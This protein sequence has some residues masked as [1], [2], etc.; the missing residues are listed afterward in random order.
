MA[1]AGWWLGVGWLT[2][3]WPGWLPIKPNAALALVLGGIALW[4]LAVE[5]VPGG[6]RAGPFDLTLSAL[7]AAI[8]LLTLVEHLSGIDLRIDELLIQGAPLAGGAATSA[9]MPPITAVGA[10]LIGSAFLLLQLRRFTWGQAV[11]VGALTL[12][13][14]PLL[15]DLYA[16]T[17]FRRRAFFGFIAPHAELGFLLLAVGGLCARV[18]YGLMAYGSGAGLGARNLR[19]VLP[20]TVVVLVTVGGLQLWGEGLGLF[21]SPTGTALMVLASLVLVGIGLW[22]ENRQTQRMERERDTFFS[23]GADL[24]CIADFEGHFL[25]VNPAFAQVLGWSDSDL[26]SRPFLEFVHPD[27]REATVA[28]MGELVTGKTTLRFLNRYGCPDG[29]WKW[30]SWTAVPRVEDGL[31]FASARDVTGLRAAQDSLQESE[32]NLAITLQSIGDGV[33]AT[34]ARGI[35]TRLNSVAETLTGWKEADALGRP[36]GEVFRVVNE[37][38]RLPAE[39]PAEAVL[40]TGS[41]QG[42]TNHTLLLARDGSERPI[43]DSAAPILD[44][45]GLL[46]GVV[47]VFRDVTAEREADRALERL[48]AELEVRVRERTAQLARSEKRLSDFFENAPDA[49]VLFDEQGKIAHVNRRTEE[50]FGWKGA[51]LLGES[52]CCLLAAEE[53]RGRNALRDFPVQSG[54]GL[55]PRQLTDLWAIRRDGTEFPVDVSLGPIKSEDGSLVAA[56]FRD[57]TERHRLEAQLNQSQKMEAIGLL[58]GGVA[59]D[60]NNVLTVI[61][62]YSALLA[63]QL[64]DDG[65]AQ[66]AVREIDTAAER[67]TDLTRQLLAFSRRQV[68]EPEVINLNEAVQEVCLMLNRVIGEDIHLRTTL[69]PVPPIRIDPGQLHHA[70]LNLAVNARDA[71]PHGGELIFETASVEVDEQYMSLHPDLRPGSWVVLLVSDSGVGMDER[72]K[73]QAFEPFFTTKETGK[74]TGLGLATVHGIVHQSGG[75]IWLY[76]EKGLGTTF[77]LHFP[78]APGVAADLPAE[79]VSAPPPRGQETILLAE[80]ERAVRVVTRL[81]LEALGYHVVEAAEGAEAIAIAKDLS[82]PI[83][84]LLT[85]VIMPRMTGREIAQAVQEVRPG[86]KVVYMS[87]Y[88]DDAVV[89]QGVQSAELVFLQKPFTTHALATKI[90]TALD[91]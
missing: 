60:F 3:L 6:R 38:T 34:D 21:D 17:G 58:A 86:I 65:E 76:S 4:R 91:G 52:V 77:K 10:V 78:V 75:H 64:P 82:L 8:G 29:T 42:L 59:H 44:R 69:R 61:R 14:V 81:G 53:S 88:T 23:L 9:R 18:R 79:E 25:R 70:M 85:D 84:L 19:W 73:A 2:T 39:I 16:A 33:L 12:F 68:L 67:A 37:H 22:L 74:G 5:R 27:D 30:L 48:N 51:D 43:A 90:R 66:D 49:M 31:I 13:A 72:T 40:A 87:G 36:V 56:S 28:E 54:S 41:I 11:L 62:G 63:E 7:V 24:F 57:E 80:D 89:R 26:I 83:H 46:I 35:V 20:L 1:I 55:A 71:M 45:G 50:L 15:G 32:E 47:L